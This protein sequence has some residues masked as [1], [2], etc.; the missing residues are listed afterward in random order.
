[1]GVRSGRWGRRDRGKGGC[2]RCDWGVGEG[3]EDEDEG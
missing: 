3:D 1:M 2:G